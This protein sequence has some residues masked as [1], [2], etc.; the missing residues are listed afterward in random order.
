M[1][2]GFVISNPAT[3]D[4]FGG[5]LFHVPS[6]K[7]PL[8]YANGVGDFLDPRAFGF[9]NN[10]IFVAGSMT[11]SGTYYT[12]AQ[13]KS[14]LVTQWMLRWFVTATAEEVGNGIDLSGETLQLM[15][16]GI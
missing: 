3:S 15:G 1:A 8:S 12:V 9:P 7:G 4:E 11:V 5:K 14:G 6:Y 13:P 16:I 10:L 2:N